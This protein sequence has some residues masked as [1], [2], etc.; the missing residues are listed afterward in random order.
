MK[1]EDL[2]F[3]LDLDG[4]IADTARFHTQA[5]HQLADKVGND[6][7]AR[8]AGKSEGRW[9]DGFAGLILKAGGHENDYTQAEK[10]ALV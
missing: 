10:D 4:V 2:K 8:T 5:W 9:P 3:C 1:F 7:D 6:L